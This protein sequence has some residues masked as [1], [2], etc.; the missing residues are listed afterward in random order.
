M[1]SFPQLRLQ[2]D[3]YL[4]V[5][6]VWSRNVNMGSLVISVSKNRKKEVK[7]LALTLLVY[8]LL[9]LNCCWSLQSNSIDSKA[10]S[11]SS[12]TLVRIDTSHGKQGIYH[13][14]ILT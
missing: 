6:L 10:S 7:S 12:I 9:G 14:N 1:V 3:F 5:T 8:F 2:N 11:P 13:E 4:A